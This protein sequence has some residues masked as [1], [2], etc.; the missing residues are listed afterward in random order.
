MAFNIPTGIVETTLAAAHD[1]AAAPSPVSA[2]AGGPV[3]ILAPPD[4]GR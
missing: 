4:R 1:G 3:T 2:L